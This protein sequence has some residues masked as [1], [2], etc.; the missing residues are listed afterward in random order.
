MVYKASYDLHVSRFD[1]M[2]ADVKMDCPGEDD[3]TE[4]E[5]YG[6]LVKLALCPDALCE[7]C[8][9]ERLIDC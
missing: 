5:A 2:G 9:E 8:S 3:Y 4:F 7:A 1:I 6:S